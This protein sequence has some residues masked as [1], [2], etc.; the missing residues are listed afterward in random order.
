G[1]GVLRRDVDGAFLERAIAVLPE[2]RKRQGSACR[3]RQTLTFR[4]AIAA[5]IENEATHGIRRI[6][7]VAEHV[8]PRAIAPLGLVLPERNQQG[9]K[10][11]HG[12]VTR[13]YGFAQRHKNRL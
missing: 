7:A 2:I 6:A 11:L 4:I 9:G 1:R 13:S 8:V 5:Q 12:N 10:W 3:V